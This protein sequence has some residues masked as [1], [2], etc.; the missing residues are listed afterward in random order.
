[1]LHA[2][3]S[4]LCHLSIIGY[5]GA[6]DDVIIFAH[7]AMQHEIPLHLLNTDFYGYV[8]SPM[9]AH[10]SLEHEVEQFVHMKI[11]NISKCWCRLK[12]R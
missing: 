8:P 5:K 3:F 6:V 1:M 10:N 2:H 7:S 12:S 9:E 4:V 11:E